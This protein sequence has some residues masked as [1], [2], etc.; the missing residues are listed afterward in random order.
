MGDW[1]LCETSERGKEGGREGMNGI[2]GG[3]AYKCRH[4]HIVY[5][6]LST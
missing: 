4:H 3:C 1:D 5:I 6:W 2:P